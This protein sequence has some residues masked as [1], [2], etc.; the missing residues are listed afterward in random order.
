MTEQAYACDNPV[1]P[2]KGVKMLFAHDTEV[3]LV[4]A[5]ALVNTASGDDSLR[6][7]ADLDQL[8]ADYG[9]MGAR[10]RDEVELATVRAL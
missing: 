3:A 1:I 6:T 4:A 9:W 8:V 5:A 2:T 7:M 10:N